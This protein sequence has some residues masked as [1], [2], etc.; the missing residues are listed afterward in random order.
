MKK[1]AR[2]ATPRPRYKFAEATPGTWWLFEHGK[3]F[4]DTQRFRQAAWAYGNN[5]ACRVQTE[6][7]AD[8]N[9]QVTGIRLLFTPQ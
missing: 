1:L 2:K 9:G 7:V 4:T 3:D 5:H 8:D 6:T